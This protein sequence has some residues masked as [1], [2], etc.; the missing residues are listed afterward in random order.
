MIQDFAEILAVREADVFKSNISLDFAYIY[1]IGRVF[2][3]DRSIHYFNIA[4]K[5]RHTLL[6]LFR[7]LNY[8]AYGGQKQGDIKDECD[9][10]GRVDFSERDKRCSENDY[11]KIHKCVKKA[12]TAVKNAEIVIT[13]LLCGQKLIGRFVKLFAFDI[14]VCK[15]FNNSNALKQSSTFALILPIFSLRNFAAL[16]I[17]LL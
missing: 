8:S 17:F 16:R 13:Q 10:I 15:G 11:R 14:L 3:R 4:F 9:K 6:E 12:Y 2:K 1:G 7:K 5:A